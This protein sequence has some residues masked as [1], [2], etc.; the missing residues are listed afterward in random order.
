MNT[1]NDM[2]T[3]LFYVSSHFDVSLPNHYLFNEIFF[4]KGH[5]LKIN[6]DEARMKKGLIKKSVNYCFKNHLDT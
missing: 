1:I 5:F 3:Q 2:S 4:K 6:K